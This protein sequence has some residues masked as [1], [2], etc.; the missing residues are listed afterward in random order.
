MFHFRQL[1]LREERIEDATSLAM[2]VVVLGDGDH[3]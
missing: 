3:V 2:H 1:S